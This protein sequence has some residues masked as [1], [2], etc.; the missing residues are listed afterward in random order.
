MD[1]RQSFKLG[2]LAH[3]IELG[4][5]SPTQI[6]GALKQAGWIKDLA[7]PLSAAGSALGSAGKLGL[8]LALAAPPLAGAVAGNLAASATDVNDFD[9][10][11]AKKQEVIDEYRRQAERLRQSG[12]LRRFTSGSGAGSQH[13][14]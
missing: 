5:T 4:Y 3:C 1:A 14:L 9:V 12:S 2:F 8:G 6:L 13:L 11:E 7:S 10:D